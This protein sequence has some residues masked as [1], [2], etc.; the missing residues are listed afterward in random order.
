V[1]EPTTYQEVYDKAYQDAL[2]RGLTTSEANAAAKGVADNWS[3]EYDPAGI[4]EEVRKSPEGAK[5]G[6]GLALLSDKKYG[7]QL[8]EVFRIWRKDKNKALDLLNKSGW[9]QLNKDA[10]DNY[11]LMLERGDIYKNLL[12]NFK[13]KINKILTEEGY[14]KLDDKALEDAF[15]SGKDEATIL[16]EALTGFKFKKG[17]TG[18]TIG[19]NYDTLVKAARRNGI[20]ESMLPNVLGFETVDDIIKAIQGG[21][22]IN[23][24][25]RKI[26][27]YAKTAMPD[28]VKGLLDEGQDLED[29]VGPY[30][31]VMVDEL[32]LP[33]NSVV[34][35]DR[36]LQDALAKQTNLADFRR[37]L[38]RDSR[39]QYTD[40]A[41]QEVSSA[42]LQVLRDFGFQG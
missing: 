36:Y 37:T 20:S 4:L 27:T 24:F 8:M 13:V 5:L 17:V 30:K 35:T 10:R 23:T 11:S 32:E 42:A 15:L 21:E 22:N 41:R 6:I 29:I 7:A 38:R 28:Y 33:Y 31:A 16:R 19:T 2:K 26:R 34:L 39:W 40:K 18:G 12:A 14:D 1:A 25:E 9:A 3:K